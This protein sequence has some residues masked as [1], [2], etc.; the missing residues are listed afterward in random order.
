MRK[1]LTML[2]VCAFAAAAQA[3]NINWQGDESNDFGTGGNWAGGA[4]PGPGDE[5]TFDSTASSFT[6]DVDSDYTI[7]DSYNDFLIVSGAYTFNGSGTI[8][9]ASS[10]DKPNVTLNLN[11]DSGQTQTLNNNISLTNSGTGVTYF[12]A[13]DNNSGG[14]VRFGGKLILNDAGSSILMPLDSVTVYY[15]GG[16]DLYNAAHANS[17]NSSSSPAFF[18]GAVTDAD[19]GSDSRFVAGGGWSVFANTNG[20]VGDSSLS[21]VLFQGGDLRL[22]ADHQVE[23]MLRTA[24]SSYSPSF[25]LNGF[26]NTNTAS[27][28]L[29]DGGSGF[30][31]TIDFS[32]EEAESLWFSDS[33]GHGWS[34]N[35][36][37][38]NL[39]GFELGKDEIRFG[40][41]ES[42][43]DGGQLSVIRIDGESGDYS[44]DNNGYLIPEPATMG[45]IG[46]TGAALLFIRRRIR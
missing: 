25:D 42:G 27:L 15:D 16:V 17:K 20:V 32:D 8:T 7:G 41:D 38:L 43:L 26:S 22:G 9:V 6:V 33:S 45:L 10:N 1:I 3:T 4:V 14:T 31:L 35:T 30:T 13:G 12:R 18:R 21:D 23:T 40:T 39:V 24:A 36:S 2:T 34:T 46:A 29:L 28:L 5:L 37:V 44:L 11:A 19:G